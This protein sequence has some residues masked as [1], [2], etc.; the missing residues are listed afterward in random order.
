MTHNLDQDQKESFDFE[1]GGMVYT[2]RY[3]TTDEITEILKEKDDKVQMDKM[4]A[5]ITPVTPDA[6][7]IKTSL[8]SKSIK[9]MQNFNKMVKEEFIGEV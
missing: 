5:F 6:P 7:D 4:Y 1:L 3:P 8:G 2:M 9:V